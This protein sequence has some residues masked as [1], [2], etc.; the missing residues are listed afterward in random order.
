MIDIL[1]H[2][3][4]IIDYLERKDSL[5]NI[6]L[7]ALTF[8]R[9]KKIE[10][11]NQ[12]DTII[13][14]LTLPTNFNVTGII[15]SVIP[16]KRK[17]YENDPSSVS[18]HYSREITDLTYVITIADIFTNDIYEILSS[19]NK[20]LENDECLVAE[21]IANFTLNVH[22]KNKTGHKINEESTNLTADNDTYIALNSVSSISEQDLTTILSSKNFSNDLIFLTSR[23]CYNAVIKIQRIKIENKR[24]EQEKEEEKKNRPL[25]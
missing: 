6:E 25:F 18:S 22:I 14:N 5:N 9:E 24:I 20:I 11:Q 21:N 8:I 7:E 19:E 12:Y 4:N 13:S 1:N 15:I 10:L 17:F 2:T 23:I 16:R 3:Q